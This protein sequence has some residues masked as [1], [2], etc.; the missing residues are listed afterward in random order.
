[1][2]FYMSHG[3]VTNIIFTSYCLLYP[4]CSFSWR[5]VVSEKKKAVWLHNVLYMCVSCILNNEFGF[6][7]H[8]MHV[9]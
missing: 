9:L 6:I 5:L 1:M 8:P 3:Y 4:V 7:A 2:H